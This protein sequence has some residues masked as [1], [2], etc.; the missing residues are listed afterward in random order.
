L[1]VSNTKS[2][3]AA[4]KVDALCKKLSEEKISA[5]MMLSKMEIGKV[6]LN[7]FVVGSHSKEREI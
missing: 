1:I 2:P 7:S 4:V 5:E 6:P 3:T